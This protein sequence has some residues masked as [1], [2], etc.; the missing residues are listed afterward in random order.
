MCGR[1]RAPLLVR[2]TI[3]RSGRNTLLKK[4]AKSLLP[5]VLD[6]LRGGKVLSTTELV[7]RHAGNGQVLMKFEKD[8]FILC[9]GDAKGVFCYDT[10]D[11]TVRYPISEFERLL[12]VNSS[13]ISIEHKEG[14][15]GREIKTTLMFNKTVFRNACAKLIAADMAKEE[16]SQR[17]ARNRAT[18]RRR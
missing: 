4:M 9:S 3:Y 5:Q 13:V 1:A 2:L 7:D 10:C 18:V 16:V 14:P 12:S 6:K 15:K 17:G 8:V 11:G